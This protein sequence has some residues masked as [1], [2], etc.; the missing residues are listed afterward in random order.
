MNF[1]QR[2]WKKS[3]NFQKYLLISGLVFSISASILTWYGVG[4]LGFK[5][6]NP[7]TRFLIN[8][9]GLISGLV[10]VEIWNAF[11]L[12]FFWSIWVEG[13]DTIKNERIKLSFPYPLIGLI[14]GG[15]VTF[16]NFWFYLID[17]SHDMIVLLFRSEILRPI[18]DYWVPFLISLF[19][20]AVYLICLK[21]TGFFETDNN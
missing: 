15:I 16:S 4:F 2:L 3:S 5:E 10:L 18:V 8:R 9:Y 1:L 20:I 7:S 13:K 21:N 12:G 14:I 17:F 6:L 11:L 19:S